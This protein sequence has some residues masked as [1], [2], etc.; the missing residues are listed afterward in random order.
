MFQRERILIGTGCWKESKEVIDPWGLSLSL[1]RQAHSRPD[2]WDK[3]KTDRQ[4]A[5][6]SLG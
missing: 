5:E 6:L 1:K 2:P 3:D 4:S